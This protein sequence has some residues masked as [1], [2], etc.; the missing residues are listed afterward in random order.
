MNIISKWLFNKH[1]PKK[2]KQAVTPAVVDQNVREVIDCIISGLEKIELIRKPN[3]DIKSPIHGGAMAMNKNGNFTAIRFRD[4]VFEAAW[5][6][7]SE[8]HIKY[9]LGA[10]DEA[11]AVSV[12]IYDEMASLL[13][14]LNKSIVSFYPNIKT[15]DS[16]DVAKVKLGKMLNNGL[17]SELQKFFSANSRLIDAVSN[18]KSVNYIESVNVTEI[19]ISNFLSR[20]SLKSTGRVF[21]D[22]VND[23]P[24]HV[25]F[26]AKEEEIRKEPSIDDIMG[27][28]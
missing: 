3:P 26:K 23:R 19:T 18:F 12:M 24:A 20:K 28:E 9:Q 6:I 16:V 1:E 11:Q 21:E 8:I 17:R 7:T 13:A 15:S 4:V 14:V 5:S 27:D 10:T 22:L 2:Q 25:S